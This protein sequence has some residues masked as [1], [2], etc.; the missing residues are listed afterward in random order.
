MMALSSPISEEDKAE[1]SPQKGVRYGS[2]T[3]TA[4]KYQ[5]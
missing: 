4:T 3:P 5:K 1:L 2:R